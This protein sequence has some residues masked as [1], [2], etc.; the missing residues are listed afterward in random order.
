MKNVKASPEAADL[1]SSMDNYHHNKPTPA[2]ISVAKRIPDKELVSAKVGVQFIREQL[3]EQLG[4]KQHVRTATKT[5]RLE[6]WK[7]MIQYGLDAQSAA[8][9]FVGRT[10]GSDA[11]EH[12]QFTSYALVGLANFFR[13]YPDTFKSRLSKGPPPPF[14]WLAWT[15]AASLVIV[16]EKGLYEAML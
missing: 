10:K 4:N 13:H 15:F 16:K 8:K 3:I 2:G 14:R 6:K 12:V 1:D 7:Q 11:F 9:V 5:S